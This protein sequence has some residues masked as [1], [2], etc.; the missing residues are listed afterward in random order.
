MRIYIM[1]LEFTSGVSMMSADKEKQPVFVVHDILFKLIII[2]QRKRWFVY[3]C[4]KSR[5][6][7]VCTL[8]M[9]DFFVD[10]CNLEKGHGHI[11]WG[12]FDKALLQLGVSTGRPLS[13]AMDG[14]VYFKAVLETM[15]TESIVHSSLWQKWLLTFIGPCAHGYRHIYSHTYHTRLHWI[16]VVFFSLYL[17]KTGAH[18]SLKVTVYS[19]AFIQV[20]LG[21]EWLLEL[22]G[23][24]S[25]IIVQPMR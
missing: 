17:G 8:W 1:L 12:V 20:R 24:F 2:T 7:P 6:S 18:F 22:S 21:N 5:F 9:A 19:V 16:S 14:M 25:K 3:S 15:W 11:Q 13:I 23:V 10:S 4:S